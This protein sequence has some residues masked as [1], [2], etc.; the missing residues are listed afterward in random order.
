MHI[1]I[2]WCTILNR[3]VSAFCFQ[4]SPLFVKGL[5]AVHTKKPLIPLQIPTTVT[6]FQA[7]ISNCNKHILSSSI[8]GYAYVVNNKSKVSTPVKWYFHAFASNIFFILQITLWCMKGYMSGALQVISQFHFCSTISSSFSSSY[9]LRKQ[10][11]PGFTNYQPQSL[12]TWMS[13]L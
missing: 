7:T 12:L 5:A 11:K 8:N 2:L 10:V 4:S 6:T 9:S 1:A 3:R 13:F